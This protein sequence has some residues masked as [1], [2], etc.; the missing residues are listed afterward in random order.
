MIG[1]GRCLSVGAVANLP[2]VAKSTAHHTI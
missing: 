1:F 2:K